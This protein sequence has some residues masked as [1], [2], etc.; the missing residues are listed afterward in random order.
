[1]FLNVTDA[2]AKH[3]LGTVILALHQLGPQGNSIT[4]SKL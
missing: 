1:M 3:T 2:F 4:E